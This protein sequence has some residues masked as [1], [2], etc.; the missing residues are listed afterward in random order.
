MPVRITLKRL[1]ECKLL[2]QIRLSFT[3]SQNDMLDRMGSEVREV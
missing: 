2:M 3:V 1:L